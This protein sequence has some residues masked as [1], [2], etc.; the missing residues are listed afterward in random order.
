MICSAGHAVS[1]SPNNLQCGN[2]L[3][4]TCSGLD[5]ADA[6]RRFCE[7]VAELGGAVVEP[8][9]LGKDRPHH[10]VCAAGHDCH[11]WG[12]AVLRG[13][14]LCVICRRSS[15]NAFYVVENG[16]LDV[17]KLGI[18]TG[19]GSVRLREHRY[20]GFTAVL[21]FL[22]GLDDAAFL[23]AHTLRTLKTAGVEPVRG[24]EYFPRSAL[25]VVL[26]LADNWI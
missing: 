16:A 24:R 2:G 14:G 1:Q 6:W 12:G 19:A 26:D 8:Q 10:V 11:P 20:D 15:S 4:Y 5:P 22:P 18:T 3:C 13:Q 7:R 9:W 17:I 21:R 25:P 23:E